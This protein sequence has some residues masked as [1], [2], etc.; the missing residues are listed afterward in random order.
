LDILQHITL[1]KAGIGGNLTFDYLNGNPQLKELYNYSPDLNGLRQALEKRSKHRVNRQ[2]LYDELHKQYGNSIHSNPLKENIQLLLQENTFTVTTGHQLNLFTGPLYFIYKIA[3]IISLTRKLSE[4][5]PGYHFV[6]VYWMNSEDHDFAEINHFYL[7]GQKFE[8]T[9]NQKKFGPVGKM[10]LESLKG[11]LD[12]LPSKTG[13]TFEVDPI[14]HFVLNTYRECS[15]LAEAHREIVNKLF[16]EHGVIILDQDSVAFKSA[17]I[18]TIRKEIFQKKSIPQLE[19]TNQLLEK[20]GYKSQVFAREI[21]FF[22]TGKMTRERIVE[23]DQGYALA[24]GSVR[25]TKVQLEQELKNNPQYFSPNVVTRPLYQEFLLPNIAYVGGPAE[26]A[27]WLQYKSNFEA[28]EIF[29]PALILRDSFLLLPEKKLRKVKE[30]HVKLE[31]F[32]GR[33]DDLINLYV[34]THLSNEFNTEAIVNGLNEEYAQL[35]AQV[36]N[37]DA[38]M[39]NMVKAAHHKALKDLEKI[40]QKLNRALKTKHE[41]QL[42][43]IRNLHT[44]IYPNGEL[45]E[46]VDNLFEHTS[47]PADFIRDIIEH[48]DPLDARLKVLVE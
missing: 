15:N 23:T 7:K 38:S 32:F 13:I 4:Q 3:S 41:N 5:I 44:S 11:L 37:V 20:K 42:N 39:D 21:N 2:L 1:E 10:E 16:G 6:P 30:L 12:E 36:V 34:K 19:A 28:H 27:Y 8:W 45:Q 14:F 48:A 33:L 17:F 26:I 25:W 9:P 46:R 47:S 35:L 43:A 18:E 31:D 40:T 24:D 22:Y 29:Y